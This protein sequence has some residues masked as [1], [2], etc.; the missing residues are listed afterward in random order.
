C[1]S[2]VGGCSLRCAVS[3]FQP[4]REKGGERGRA[5]TG[6]PRLVTSSSRDAP[7]PPASPPLWRKG[8][9]EGGQIMETT[10]WLYE[11]ADL[12]E[13]SIYFT[14]GDLS[15]SWDSDDEYEK[16]IRRM[17]PPRY[18]ISFRI[19]HIMSLVFLSF[20]PQVS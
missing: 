4:Y 12:R 6:S 1:V 7:Q 3:A 11:F 9:G 2:G 20:D 18:M 10:C 19:R 17:N 16:F 5:T 8:E 13:M 14:A 15:S